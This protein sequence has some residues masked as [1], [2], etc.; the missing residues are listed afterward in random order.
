M[1]VEGFEFSADALDY[2]TI[3]DAICLHYGLGYSNSSNFMEIVPGRGQ[4]ITIIAVKGSVTCF[5]SAYAMKDS[6]QYIV[7]VSSVDIKWNR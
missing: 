2:G 6:D 1:K 4:S 7:S 3:E 5:I